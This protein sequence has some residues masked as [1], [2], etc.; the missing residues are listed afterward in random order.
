[1][2][3]ETCAW[4]GSG[5]WAMV[6]QWKGT[7]HQNAKSDLAALNSS[8][9]FLTV[10]KEEPSN[11]RHFK[12][13]GWN[14]FLSELLV[15]GLVYLV[16]LGK[17][18][19]ATQQRSSPLVGN[20]VLHAA[21]AVG[22]AE[23]LPWEAPAW[24]CTVCAPTERVGKAQPSCSRRVPVQHK[25]SESMAHLKQMNRVVSRKWGAD[26]KRQRRKVYF[27]YKGRKVVYTCTM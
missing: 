26:V 1:M 10:C 15:W 17:A 8:L 21:E 18:R 2:C 14:P 11:T 19:R 27:V 6:A 25:C 7:T 20:E 5:R 9:L 23:P 4:D 16:V 13:C 24:P 12:P 22:A 3:W